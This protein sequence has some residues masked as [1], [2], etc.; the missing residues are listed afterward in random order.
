MSVVSAA[1]NGFDAICS[2]IESF[3]NKLLKARNS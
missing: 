1:I 3:I 2:K